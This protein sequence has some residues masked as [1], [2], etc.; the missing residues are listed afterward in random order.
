VVDTVISAKARVAG[1]F[2][3]RLFVTALTN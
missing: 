3:V 1:P 2:I